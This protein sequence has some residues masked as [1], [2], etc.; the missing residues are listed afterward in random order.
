MVKVMIQV[1]NNYVMDMIFQL[2]H[3]ILLIRAVI[4]TMIQLS[5]DLEDV[6]VNVCVI[7]VLNILASQNL[8]LLVSL[9]LFIFQRLSTDK[10]SAL[11]RK[12]LSWEILCAVCDM[13]WVPLLANVTQPLCTISHIL[14]ETKMTFPV[15]NREKGKFAITKKEKY[16]LFCFIQP[17]ACIEI[18]D[19]TATVLQHLTQAKGFNRL[20]PS[21]KNDIR[22]L[23]CTVLH[24]VFNA[25]ALK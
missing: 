15:C 16:S 9:V 20:F 11:Q 25:K 23:I 1:Q 21:D 12:R 13:Q 8:T 19:W 6:G 14:L 4:V 18:K 3:Q 22:R 10:P 2:I 5:R 24:F 17:R 7:K